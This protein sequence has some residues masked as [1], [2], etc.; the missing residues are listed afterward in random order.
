MPN[1]NPKNKTKLALVKPANETL[2]MWNSW[3]DGMYGAMDHLAEGNFNIKVFGYAEHPATLKRG[4]LTLHLVTN[5]SSMKYWLK[6]FNAPIILGWGTAFDP[7]NEIISMT[8]RKILLYA[9][10]P[11][12]SDNAFKIF[13][14]VVVENESDRKH[15]KGSIAA[16][17]T[18]TKV[19]KPLKGFNKLFPSFYPAAFALYKRHD[20]WAK[21]MPAGSLAVGHMQ[22]H[23]P[24]CYEVCME[25][26]HIVTPPLPMHIMPHLY[27]HSVG[28]CLTPENMGGCQRAALEAMACNIPVLVTNDSKAA[29]FEGVWACPPNVE[30]IKAAYLQMI[31]AFEN[32]EIDLRKEYILGKYDEVTYAN[33]LKEILWKNPS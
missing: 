14:M 20:L 4:N 24:Q 16:F 7:W 18:N 12:D 6:A 26:G 15:F 8:A 5:I 21:A 17:G 9:G 31:L 23:E 27:A 33:K 3:C 10:G 32:E 2:E 29:E 22:D 19:F 30:D 28:V 1:D 25:N 13:D 11:Y